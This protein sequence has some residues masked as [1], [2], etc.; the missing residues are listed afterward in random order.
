MQ[1]QDGL[2]GAMLLTMLRLSDRVDCRQRPGKN[3]EK[4]KGTHWAD[5]R[6]DREERAR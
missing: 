4:Q 3:T 6:K 1:K 2:W 5:N